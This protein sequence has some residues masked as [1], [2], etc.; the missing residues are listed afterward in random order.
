MSVSTRAFFAVL[1]FCSLILP[2]MASAQDATHRALISIYHAA[3]GK[4]LDLL[5]WFAAREVADREAG[6][7]PT[8]VYAHVDGDSWDYLAIGPDIDQATS[9]RVD[10][11]VRK[12][13]MTAGPKASLELRTM[14]LS[15]TDTYV[16]GP[17]TASEL[18][19]RYSRP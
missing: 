11:L 6:V 1:V 12:H 15:H 4:Q 2:G 3:P 14:I 5:K 13:G 9:G 8:Q 7:T 19:D 18:V 16:V 17:Y 10:A